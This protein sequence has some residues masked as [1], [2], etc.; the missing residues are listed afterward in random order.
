MMVKS[1]RRRGFTVN[2][3]HGVRHDARHVEQIIHER[4]QVRNFAQDQSQAFQPC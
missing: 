2:L 4:R 1:S 3:L